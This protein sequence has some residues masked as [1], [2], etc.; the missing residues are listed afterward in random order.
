L[1]QGN[2]ESASIIDSKPIAVRASHG[3]QSLHLFLFL[4]S[5]L[6]SDAAERAVPQPHFAAN[7]FPSS[8]VFPVDLFMEKDIRISWYWSSLKNKQTAQGEESCD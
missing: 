4:D 7:L 2:T 5:L 8:K 1:K 3:K 6:V